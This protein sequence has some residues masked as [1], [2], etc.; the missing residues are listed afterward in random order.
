MIR[1]S[2]GKE[3]RNA[4]QAEKQRMQRNGA[5]LVSCMSG[6]ESTRSVM[7][8]QETPYEFPTTLKT[9]DFNVSVDQG[10]TAH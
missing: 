5:I 1:S 8:R 2:L 10:K 4:L 7:L 9:L 6:V 3:W